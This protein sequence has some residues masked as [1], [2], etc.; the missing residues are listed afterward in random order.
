MWNNVKYGFT[1]NYLKQSIVREF[2]CRFF[3]FLRVLASMVFFFFVQAANSLNVGVS[4]LRKLKLTSRSYDG[5]NW[6]VG[7]VKMFFQHVAKCTPNLTG[8]SLP[9]QFAT[10]TLINSVAEL[11]LSLE[12][13]TGAIFCPQFGLSFRLT[14]GRRVEIS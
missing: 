5:T 8:L 10:D 1:A 2:F 11:I 12:H 3:F 7:D 4:N 6:S 13:L 9:A 14:F